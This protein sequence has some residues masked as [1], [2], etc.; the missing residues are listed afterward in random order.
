MPKQKNLKSS[1]ICLLNPNSP[2]NFK[3][4]KQKNAEILHF[5]FFVFLQDCICDVIFSE[6]EAEK[7]Q[8]G[9]FSLAQIPDFGLR[10]LENHLAH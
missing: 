8:N 10:Y 7:L 4:I 1:E 6:N 2:E 3:R 5:H 9:D